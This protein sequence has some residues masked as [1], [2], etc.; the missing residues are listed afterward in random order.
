MN[1]VIHR[2]VFHCSKPLHYIR[3][4][5]KFKNPD[6]YVLHLGFE[7]RTFSPD[8]QNKLILKLSAVFR[9]HYQERVVY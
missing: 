2:K 9:N 8:T 6:S 5:F 1:Y 7:F 4:V 3:D